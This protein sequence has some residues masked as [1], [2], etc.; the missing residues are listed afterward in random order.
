MVE[1]SNL[2]T[3]DY[4]YK[5]VFLCSDLSTL[6]SVVTTLAAMGK[7]QDENLQNSVIV[8]SLTNCE[9]TSENVS[10]SDPAAKAFDALAKALHPPMD[11]V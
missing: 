5:C 4:Y 10:L 2:R 11:Q 6:A 3:I 1:I 9:S 8:D 7:G